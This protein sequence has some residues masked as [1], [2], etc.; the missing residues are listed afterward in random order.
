MLK[1]VYKL[2]GLIVIFVIS[3]IG[4]SYN[5][6]EVK[7]GEDSKEVVMQSGETFPIV[8]VNSQNYQMNRLYGYSGNMAAGS[9]RESI[10]PLDDSKSVTVNIN[11]CSTPINKLNYEVRLVTTNELIDSGAVSAF[12]IDEQ[13]HKTAK[14][15][16][17]VNFKPSTEYTLKMILVTDVSK[18][19]SYYTRLKYYAEDSKL[20]EK[21]DFVNEI[22]KMTVTKNEKL[23]DYIE[24]DPAADN[25]SL[26]FVDIHSSYE[27]ITWG[28][29]V[30]VIITD[31]IPT[32]KE[33]NMETAAVSLV[34]YARAEMPTGLETFYVKEYYRVKYS[35]GRSYLL[36]FERSVEA[37]YD[38]LL[39]SVKKSQLK[40]GISRT[41]DVQLVSNNANTRMAFTR[42]GNVYTYDL[43]GNKINR[44]Y[45]QYINEEDFEH[46]LYRQQDIHILSIDEEGNL[47][48]AVYGYISHGA[49]EGKV[50]VVL[51]QYS[52]SDNATT[53]LLYI[54]FDMTYQILRQEFERYCYINTGNVFYFSINNSIYSYNIVADKLT[55]IAQ[56]LGD[57]DY[58]IIKDTNS[59]VWEVPTEDGLAREISILNMDTGANISIVAQPGEYLRLTGVID[60]NVVYGTGRDKDI[61]MTAEG[62]KIYAL[63][64]IDIVD[65]NGS[66]VKSYSKK[67]YYIVDANVEGNVVYMERC[68]K[69]KGVYYQVSGDNILNRVQTRASSIKLTSR[70]TKKTLTEWYID[71]PSS[72][73]MTD[74]P[75]YA[76]TNS[77]YVTQE[78]PIY[79][80]DTK[81]NIRYYVYAKGDIKGAY[82]SPADAI[83]YADEEQGVVIGSNNQLIWERGGRFNAH[84]I[85]GINNIGVS[86]DVN[87]MEA[88][89]YMLL[90]AVHVSAD[91]KDIK[92]QN[93]SILDILNKY[94]ADAV[95]LTGCSFDEILYY[96]SG[97]RPVIGMTGDNHA[98]IITAYSMNSVTIYDPVAGSSQN[99]LHTAA[100]SMFEAAGNVFVSIAR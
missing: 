70:V 71:L 85:A 98:V 35:G 75:Q 19:I 43:M 42:G 93:M 100:S 16:F 18:K 50:A 86:A 47:C 72:F 3:V 76:V 2:L 40:I 57:D 88:C 32:V 53:E 58:M 78:H 91:I 37:E 25:S 31:I 8:E 80:E 48:F 1:H 15:T 90:N 51:Y 79:L 33:Y 54:P 44:I 67:G 60:S 92:G 55:C 62:R 61:G 11:E 68:K 21:L 64:H 22:H 77:Y 41:E 46:K 28:E 39:T 82:N 74:M 94:S 83:V 38:V 95:N 59:Y 66:I 23:A 7:I 9:I 30:P 14:L 96:V 99:M 89:A 20:K 56:G 49:Y 65:A 73:K 36:W 87:S 5:I 34:Y 12:D 29:F 10:T 52:M 84:I 4:F 13:E 45:S 24:P 63:N 26:A 17:D 27:N 69:K 97:D 6:G 81:Q